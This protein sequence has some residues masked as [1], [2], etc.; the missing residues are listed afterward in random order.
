MSRVSRAAGHLSEAALK[1]KI[2]NA[3]N[4]WIQQKWMI[5]YNACVD[6]RPAREI[7]QHTATSVRTVHQVIAD[8]NRN[9]ESAIET[10]GRGGRRNEYLTWSEEVSFLAPFIAPSAEGELTTIQAIH[11]AFEQRVGTAVHA[12]TIYRLLERHGWRKLVPRPYHPE[13]DLQ[14]QEAFKKTFPRWFNPP[15]LVVR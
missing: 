13:G 3:P 9:G 11:Q 5:V 6:P 10:V 1:D 12:S 2:A 8:Y 7:A 14:A 4:A 15:S